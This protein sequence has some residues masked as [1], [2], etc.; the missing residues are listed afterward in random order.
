MGRGARRVEAAEDAGAVHQ[1]LVRLPDF[2][3]ERFPAALAAVAVLAARHVA[4]CKGGSVS[5]R[6]RRWH[7]GVDVRP[8]QGYFPARALGGPKPPRADKQG[9]GLVVMPKPPGGQ[10]RFHQRRHLLA[11]LALRRAQGFIDE[12]HAD[13]ATLRSRQPL[14]LLVLLHQPQVVLLQTPRAPAKLHPRR[15]FRDFRRR[16]LRVEDDLMVFDGTALRLLGRTLLLALLLS[17]LTC[18]GPLPWRQKEELIDRPR[19]RL[20]GLQLGGRRLGHVV[21][22]LLGQGGQLFGQA[23]KNLPEIIGPL[24]VD[25]L[26]S[27]RMGGLSHHHRRIRGL[28]KTA[29]ASRLLQE[30]AGRDF[31]PQVHRAAQTGYVA[32]VKHPGP[33]RQAHALAEDLMYSCDPHL[34][35]LL[36]RP[37]RDVKRGRGDELD[38]IREAIGRLPRDMAPS[39]DGDVLVLAHGVEHPAVVEVTPRC[40]PLRPLATRAD[41]RASLAN[42]EPVADDVHEFPPDHAVGNEPRCIDQSAQ[43]AAIHRGIFHV[44]PPSLRWSPAR[45]LRRRGLRLGV[46][47]GAALARGIM[48]KQ[49]PQRA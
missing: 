7:Q 43:R 40:V 30:G 8:V 38:E 45:W 35:S 2:G 20:Q 9:D 11:Q 6:R 33:S 21:V 1:P 14:R 31:L 27:G 42:A 17:R 23:H 25:R 46:G 15:D 3:I 32:D 10:G 34:G 16:A 4:S 18:V 39:N 44:V 49:P 28:L 36:V 13:A 5:P 19:L 12:G 22:R 29:T 48:V 26:G 47:I 37:W 41:G 24:S